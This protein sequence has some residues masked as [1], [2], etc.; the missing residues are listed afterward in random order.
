[1]YVNMDL[2]ADVWSLQNNSPKSPILSVSHFKDFLVKKWV[3]TLRLKVCSHIEWSCFCNKV[4]VSAACEH[5]PIC[6]L[7]TGHLLTTGS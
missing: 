3:R 2:L 7:P 1:M 6:W 5:T 4:S